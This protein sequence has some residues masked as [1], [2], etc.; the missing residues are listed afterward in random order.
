MTEVYSTRTARERFRGEC[1]CHECAAKKCQ[2]GLNRK[3]GGRGLRRQMGDIKRKKSRTAIMMV[4]S[5]FGHIRIFVSC[6]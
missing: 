2:C 1:G 5:L 3:R 6:A 4:T